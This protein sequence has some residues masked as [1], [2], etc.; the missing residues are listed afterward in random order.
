MK[1]LLGNLIFFGMLIGF[2]VGIHATYLYG[3]PQ[4]KAYVFKKNAEELERMVYPRN[5]RLESFTAKVIKQM[6]TDDVPI[7]Y[8]DLD[9]HL[10][11]EMDGN[12]IMHAKVIWG[13]H[14]E[15]YDDFPKDCKFEVNIQ[16]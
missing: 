6:K 5:K 3:L 2:G 16:K 7:D 8:K 4:Y 10:F 9:K 1:K 14:V 13:V 12:G 15:Y 11:I